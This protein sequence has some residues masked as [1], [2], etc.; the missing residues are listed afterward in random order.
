M[1]D[2]GT[3]PRADRSSGAAGE[4]DDPYALGDRP[5]MVD[6]VWVMTRIIVATLL[7]LLGFALVV[8]LVFRLA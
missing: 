4:P 7:I 1:P 6:Q 8:G 2:E 5:S 3:D